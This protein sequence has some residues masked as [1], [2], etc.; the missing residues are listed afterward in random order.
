M[1]KNIA[2]FFGGIVLFVFIFITSIAWSKIF[3]GESKKGEEVSVLNIE[4][5]SNGSID[6][7]QD[8]PMD[9]P[10][11]D[12]VPY[13]FTVS[14]TSNKDSHYQLLIE[15]DPVSNK[16]GYRQED[17]LKRSQLEYE[18]KMN[19]KVIHKGELSSIKKND[20]DERIIQGKQKNSYELT[21]WVH[22]D[23]NPGEW[24]NKF[25]HYQVK[26]KVIGA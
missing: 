6:T 10:S 5:S 4:Y 9:N 8:A 26:T 24:E 16:V 18:L 2:L 22:S 13:T 17:L 20:L 19:G 3:Y 25:Y 11:G 23:V 14:N 12:M 1:K 21:I 15:E 7:T